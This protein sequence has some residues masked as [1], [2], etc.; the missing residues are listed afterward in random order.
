MAPHYV[1][2]LR[3][4]TYPGFPPAAPSRN[5]STGVICRVESHLLRSTAIRETII[6]G[7]DDDLVQGRD[8]SRLEVITGVYTVKIV[9]RERDRTTPTPTY[10]ALYRKF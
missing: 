7:S 8:G 2:Y 6:R 1:K 10:T 3:V 4:L 5:S 9:G